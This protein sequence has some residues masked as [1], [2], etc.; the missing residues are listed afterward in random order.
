MYTDKDNETKGKYHYVSSN[1]DFTCTK[2]RYFKNNAWS[3]WSDRTISSKQP[4]YCSKTGKKDYELN[5]GDCPYSFNE[6]R[7][8]NTNT[9]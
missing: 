9:Y 3:M 6:F 1:R 5:D 4:T 2:C 8:L 7:I